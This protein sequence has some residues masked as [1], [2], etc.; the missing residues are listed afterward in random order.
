MEGVTRKPNKAS[1]KQVVQPLYVQIRRDIS[2]PIR[3]GKLKPGVRIPSEHAL[4]A[5]YGASRMT[6]NKALSLLADEG[7]IRR[8]RKIGSFVAESRGERAVFE[9][10][11]LARDIAAAGQHYAFQLISSELVVSGSNA[12]AGINPA[13]GP[14][15]LA[16]VGLHLADGKPVQVEERWINLD[17]APKAATVDFSTEPPGP[18]LLSHVHWSEAEHTVK[19][20]AADTRLALLL[21]RPVGTALL[22][23][24]RQTWNGETPVTF[25]RLFQPG[26]GATLKGRFTP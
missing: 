10:W 17:S 16:L 7:L 13:I 20:L 11:N 22:V 9:I 3:A 23:V 19:A 21:E 1:E 18:W 8:H 5:K 14:N 6:V 26:D 2:D 4:M 24:E 12:S 25:A 15:M